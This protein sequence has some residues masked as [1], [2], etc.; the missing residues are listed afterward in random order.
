MK[1]TRDLEFIFNEITSYQNNNEL[2]SELDW[3]DY[4][5]GKNFY[6]NVSRDEPQT[7][8]ETAFIKEKLRLKPGIKILD[9][10]CGGGRNSIKL[11]QAGFQVTGVDLN[12]YALEQAEINCP[13][14]LMINFIHQ[15]IL[16]LNYSEEFQ[17]VILIFNH[18]S[19]FNRPDVKKL[20]HKISRALCTEGKLLIEIPSIAHGKSLD[21][22][23]EWQIT[24]SWLS[25]DFKQLVLSENSFS[26]NSNIHL[27]KDFCLRMSDG[28]L[29]AYKQTSYLYEPEEI[30]ELL[31]IF[32]LKLVQTYGDWLGKLYDENDEQL[33]IVAQK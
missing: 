3:K 21:G 29:D 15:D 27:R 2:V 31:K 25:G 7:E 18:F 26:E 22:L 33:I 1:N 4:Q 28:N 5:F 16:D 11:A 14:D 30:H 24:D 20:L 19:G 23:R 9:L 32:G 12:K 17:A 10:G 8:L 6:L 13:K